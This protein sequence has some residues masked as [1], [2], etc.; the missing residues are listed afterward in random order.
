MKW[1][2]QFD[3]ENDGGH[4]DEKSGHP[5]PD[6]EVITYIIVTHIIIHGSS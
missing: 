6:N 1:V 4:N 5:L 3:E 2:T